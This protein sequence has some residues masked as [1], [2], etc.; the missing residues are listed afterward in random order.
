ME[1]L[2]ALVIHSSRIVVT[3]AMVAAAGVAGWKMWNHYQHDPWTR[4]GRVRVDIVSV[5]PDVSGL[6]TN[7]AVTH[8]QKVVK[9]QPLFTI[10]RARYELALRQAEA[11]IATQ[12]AAISVQQAT[13]SAHRAA[14]AE[15]EREA[16]RNDKLGTFV[17]REVNEQSHTKV[18]QEQAALAQAEAAVA[19]AVTGVA[20][21]EAARDVAT[22]NLE[23]TLVRSQVDGMASD[24]SL[25]SGDYVSPGKPVL[26]L[27]DAASLR[28][29]GYFEETKLPGLHVGQKV[30]VH[31]MGE[32]KPLWGHIQSI[33]GAIED[34]ER[35]PSA[36]LL[37][38]VNPT[39][40]WVRL[41]QRIPV[42]I[43]LDA[44][45]PDLLLIAGR[46]AS[47]AVVDETETLQ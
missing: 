38:N 45:P 6:V 2:K 40:S 12:K 20:Q 34:R 36:S 3:L 19:Q 41:A 39:F 17:A 29:E 24:I 27:I 35:G 9:G 13:V 28:V 8:D 5:T 46:T 23:R 10:D 31:L 16:A 42:R 32:D 15:A 21:A 7:V 25:R 1:K 11:T 33:A 4:D 47:V 22:L 18:A 30:K 44:P 43:A 14:L 26:A 37:P